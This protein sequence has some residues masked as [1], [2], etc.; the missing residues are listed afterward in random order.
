[1]IQLINRNNTKSH[2][3]IRKP[4]VSEHYNK[5]RYNGKRTDQCKQRASLCHIGLVKD[6]G[7]K[8]FKRILLILLPALSTNDWEC[9]ESCA[10][11]R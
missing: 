1:M 8:F 5:C 7:P 6:H 9:L 10:N 2:R 3:A 11:L 4:I